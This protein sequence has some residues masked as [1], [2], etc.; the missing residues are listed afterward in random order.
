MQT[1]L[2]I[3]PFHV[4]SICERA[5]NFMD[6]YL[7]PFSFFITDHVQKYQSFPYYSSPSSFRLSTSFHVLDDH[8]LG[9]SNASSDQHYCSGL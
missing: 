9:K 5:L 2:L 3:G 6:W 8:I 1:V 7:L 4:S